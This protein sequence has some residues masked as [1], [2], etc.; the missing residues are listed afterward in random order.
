MDLSNLFGKPGTGLHAIRIPILDIAFIDTLFTFL[1]AYFIKNY[2]Y[3]KTQYTTLFIFMCLFVIGEFFHLI[4]KVD[5]KVI[6]V[7]SN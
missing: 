2:Y 1:L 7:I 5:T 6:N 4:F 3:K